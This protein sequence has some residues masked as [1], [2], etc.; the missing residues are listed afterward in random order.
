M[1]CSAKRTNG[2]PC[3]GQAISGGVVCRV[4]GG[5][6]PQ[7]RSKALERLAMAFDPALAYL[8]RA[9][10]Q[11]QINAAGVTAARDLL[12]R[13]GFKPADKQEITGANG[14]PLQGKIEIVLI[15]GPKQITDES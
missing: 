2:Q 5:A 8:L 9:S 13:A 6:A 4:H 14:G 15:P 7:V 10:R 11:K 3:K 1:T 12:D